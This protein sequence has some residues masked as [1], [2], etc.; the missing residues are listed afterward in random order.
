MPETCLTVLEAVAWFRGKMS[1]SEIYRMATAGQ[2]PILRFRGKILIPQRWLEDFP[3]STGASAGQPSQTAQGPQPT[4]LGA[5]GPFNP[6]E[7]L[8]EMIDDAFSNL[9]EA[10]SRD[11]GLRGL[12]WQRA[13]PL[14]LPFWGDVGFSPT[15]AIPSWR[16]CPGAMRRSRGQGAGRVLRPP[17]SFC[18][19]AQPFGVTPGLR[20]HMHS[21]SV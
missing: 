18:P 4:S 20:N 2:I 9:R 14:R 16:K 15:A 21:W 8:Q 11:P 12:T 3:N 17:P 7:A 6:L 1:R 10:A 19:Q 13:H 5:K